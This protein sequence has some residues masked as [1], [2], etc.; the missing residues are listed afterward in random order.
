MQLIELQTIS[1]A[2]VFMGVVVATL[3]IIY[4]VR[5]ARKTQT[6]VFLFESRKDKEYLESLYML[7]KV[8]ASGRSFRS[9]V[10]PGPDR[11]LTDKERVER[12]KLQ[13]ILNFYERVAVSIREGIYNEKMIKQTSYATVIETWDIAEPL[14]KA[15][16]QYINSETTWQE[17][18]WL[19]SRWRKAPLKRR[20]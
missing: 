13:Y 1:N 20:R 19:V 17:F 7:K 8:Y 15:V 3:A 4:N 9:Y 12:L 5:I 10:F 14:I 11:P 18:E 6:A 16:R 2:I